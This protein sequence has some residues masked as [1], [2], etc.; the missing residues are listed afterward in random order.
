MLEN[1]VSMAQTEGQYGHMSISLKGKTASSTA[2][3][4]LSNFFP[5]RRTVTRAE[6]EFSKDQE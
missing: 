5:L 2:L 1:H 6:L 4:D 3:F